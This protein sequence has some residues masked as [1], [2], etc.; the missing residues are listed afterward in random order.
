MLLARGVQRPPPTI[1]PCSR[2]VDRADVTCKRKRKDVLVLLSDQLCTVIS[3][4]NMQVTSERAP[5][6]AYV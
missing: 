5:M 4:Q 2:V 6:L 1:T 3:A